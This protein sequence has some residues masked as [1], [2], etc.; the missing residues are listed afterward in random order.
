MGFGSK[1][2]EYRKQ[3][4]MTL[5]QLAEQLGVSTAFLSSIE[6]DKKKPSLEM[7]RKIATL[8]NISPTYLFSANEEKVHGEKIKFIREGRSLSIEE[9]AE[10]VELPPGVLIKYEANETVPDMETLEKLADVLN[11]SVRYFLESSSGAMTV[12][13]R[14]K[15]VR[16]RLGWT[17]LSL[18]D[19]AGVSPGLIS[20]IESN[21]TQ[22]SLDTLESIAQSLN[23]SVCYFL[24]EHEDVQ[25]LLASLGPEVLESL[26]DPR[27]QAVLRAIRDFDA[28]ELKYI[29]NQIQF[30]KKNRVLL[31]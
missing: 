7:T 9:L 5:A 19:K 31:R 13:E 1:I 2:R 20:Q 3:R 15:A 26:G 17:S 24:L 23:V 21:R 25:D 16:E 28:G 30:F 29:L 14:V 8:L 6:R 22:P 27:V 12:G 18:A 11:V 4:A 10:M